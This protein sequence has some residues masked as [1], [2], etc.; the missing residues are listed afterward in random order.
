[1]SAFLLS[2]R[3]IHVLLAAFWLGSAALLALF[4]EPAVTE[5]GPAG[6]TVMQALMRRGMARIL[7]WVGVFTVLSGI[8]LLWV[9][10]GHFASAYM[11]SPQGVLISLGALFGIIALMLGV[12][13]TRP[14]ATGLAAIGERVAA[15]GAPPSP[16][17]LAV[18]GRL[19]RRLRLST[20]LVALTL[21]AAI[22]CMAVG[23]HL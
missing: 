6:G 18:M 7:T 22:V 17:D 3:A 13:L 2:I 21:V 14:A 23:S 19:S 20:R 12:H 1:M 11:G 15:S 10:S 9:R 4:I 16:E 8:Y 5:A